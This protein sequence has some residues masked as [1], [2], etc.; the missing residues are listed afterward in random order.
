MSL[1]HWLARLGMFPFTRVL[2][3]IRG[4]DSACRR[5]GCEVTF[6]RC[7]SPSPLPWEKGLSIATRRFLTLRSLLL[8]P[9]RRHNL[10]LPKMRCHSFQSFFTLAALL[11]SAVATKCTT[12]DHADHDST[13]TSTRTVSKT[14]T[15]TT[16]GY[17]TWPTKSRT[18][19]STS[20]TSTAKPP[21][22]SDYWLEN[23][24]HQGV[25]PYS[26]SPGY[27]V[28]RNVKDYGAKGD[29][30]TDD[31]QAIQKAISEGGRC[32]PGTCSGSTTTPAL[33]YFPSGTYL[34]TEPIIQYYYTNLIGNPSCLP[35]IKVVSGRFNGR[36]VLDSNPYGYQPDGKLAWGATNVFFRQVANFVFDL[37]GITTSGA[38]ELAAIHWPS[39][40]ATSLSNIVF[41]LNRDKT[42]KQE[43]IFIEE[44][45]GGFVGD[46]V[47]D[48]G[49]QGLTVG[50]QQF[51][52]RNIS[53]S[54]AGI[55]VKQL[56]D[57]GWTYQDI[58]IRNC[59]V[60]FDISSVNGGSLTV[61]SI[62]VFD[63][64]ITDTTVGVKFGSPQVQQPPISN[65]IILENVKINRV[66]VAV[67]GPLGETVLDGTPGSTT[68][69]AWGRGN[70]YTPD[71]PK[72]F[73]APFTPNSRPTSLT[74]GSAY[75]TRSKPQ[76]V[77]EPVSN[78][79]SARSEG[80]KGDGVAD[81]TDALNKLIA[82]AAKSG[83]IV[84]LDAGYYRVTST[85]FIP[86]GSRITGEAYPIILSSGKFFANE[87]EPKPVVQIGK[88]GSRGA[89]EWSNTIV[90]T[91]GYQPGAI[92]IEYNLASPTSRPSGLW[93]VHV[94]I[95]GFAGSE[96]QLKECAKTPDVK[97]DMSNLDKDCIS[98]FLSFH[99]TRGS[100]GLLMENC[101]VW[102]ADHDLEIGANNQQITIYTGRGMLIESEKGGIWLYGTGVEH[103][104]MY[105]YQL[106]KSQAVVM[107][108]IQTETAY[109]QPNPD[110]RI[111][112][113]PVAKYSD[114]E[115]KPG[116]S[117]WGLRL[118]DSEKTFVYGASLYS[119]FDNYSTKCSDI[120]AGARCQKRIFSVENSKVSV[121]NLNTVGTTKM[122]TVDGVDKADYSENMDGFV[123]TIALFRNL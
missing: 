40:Q 70:S 77:N 87:A 64:E 26:G 39:S 27:S 76:Y 119:F 37:T 80:C 115:F 13:T 38:E 19:T 109:Y 74:A 101:W 42:V 118:V 45:S 107:G 30:V 43:A 8:S 33:V 24:K 14:T 22:C 53:I 121:Y 72:F 55:A 88:P 97:I 48:G 5:L 73:Q 95:G 20:T 12:G 79:L 28:F 108:Q 18:T 36:W 6:L 68:I 57:W 63:S 4:W 83:K 111:P 41:K 52:F 29:G 117:G 49:Y 103:H 84:F 61:G 112:F 94:R 25:A 85:I 123:Q 59:D 100:S 113:S 46:L 105:E 89:V 60:G 15:V 102:V 90:S 98:G 51:T 23:I 67:Q 58:K 93:D 34:V 7:R 17:D 78:F 44:G 11:S 2:W 110:A 81:D 86:E 16:S 47:I 31:T 120:G 91:K 65:N 35:V 99:I 122:V 69:A 104:Q 9:L 114:P 62:T 3:V 116:E 10:C 75:Y 32:A 82:K 96:L 92:L 21:G 1:R 66:G 106:V 50:N 56:W 71:G 54:N